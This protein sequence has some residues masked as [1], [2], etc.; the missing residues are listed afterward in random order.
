[1]VLVLVVVYCR[2]CLDAT[3]WL[4][5]MGCFW[6]SMDKKTFGYRLLAMI[7]MVTH[8]NLGQSLQ[9]EEKVPQLIFTQDFKAFI[10]RVQ[11]ASLHRT[12][13]LKNVLHGCWLLQMGTTLLPDA[14]AGAKE[15]QRI[16]MQ[17][18]LKFSAE[19][20]LWTLRC[21]RRHRNTQ[22]TLTSFVRMIALD[23]RVKT[24]I[25]SYWICIIARLKMPSPTL[26]QPFNWWYIIIKLQRAGM[27]HSEYWCMA[28]NVYPGTPSCWT[29]DLP[30]KCL[31]YKEK[32]TQTKTTV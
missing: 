17:R 30:I 13:L 29:V 11:C 15:E 8:Q 9:E 19:I 31:V 3:G 4:Y 23:R 20:L 27:L 18:W 24:T 16:A 21:S 7:A 12:L 25:K 10:N 28:L 22:N 1:M 32:A 26:S 2:Y 6:K 14:V 5:R